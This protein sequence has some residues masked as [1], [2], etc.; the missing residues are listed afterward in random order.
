MMQKR[1]LYSLLLISFI[2][3]LAF[4]TSFAQTVTFESKNSLRCDNGVANINLS[5]ADSTGA[6]EIVFVIASGSGGAA[7]DNWSVA[8]DASFTKL[9]LRVVDTTSMAD[10]VLPDT[11]RISAIKTGPS[12]VLLAGNYLIAKVNFHTNDVCSGTVTMTGSTFAYAGGAC[13]FGCGMAVPVIQTQFANASGTAVSPAVVTTG[14]ITIVNTLPTIASIPNATLHWGQTFVDTAVGSD[15]DLAKGCEVLSYSKVS[16]PSALNVNSSTGAISWTTTGADVCTHTVTVK[17]TDKC[18]ASAQTSFDICVQNTPP[19]ITCPAT[20]IKIVLGDTAF[21]TI[22]GTDADF[23]PKPLIYKIVSFSGPG[24]PVINPATGAFSWPTVYDDIDFLGTFTACVEVTDS[25]NVCSPCS[26]SNADTCCFTITVDWGKVVIEKVHNQIQGQYTTVDITL[27]TNYPVGGF[28][29]LIQYD[30]SALTFTQAL[31][32]GFLTDCGWEYFTYRT[33]PFG[34]CGTGCPTGLIK[35]VAIAETNNGANHPGCFTNYPPPP[36]VDSVIAQLEFLVSNDFTLECQFVPI[37]FY[38]L[39]CTDNAFSNLKGD[40]LLI[41]RKVFDYVGGGGSDSYYEITDPTFG[42]PTW[43]GAQAECDIVNPDKPEV[44]RIIDFFD[45]GIDIVCADSIDARGDINLNGLAY[46]IADVVNFTNYFIVGLGAFTVNVNG[47]IAATDVNA[48]G[49]TLSVADLV[50]L[51]RVVVG[52]ALP[53][54]KISP[55]AVNYTVENGVVSVEGNMGAAFIVAEGN[56]TPTLLANN[57]LM[58]AQFDGQNTRILVYPPFDG[59]NHTESF[60]GEFVTVPSSIVSIEMATAEGAPAALRSVPK[61]YSLSQNYPNPFNPT[62]TI[63]FALPVAG[64]YDLAIYNVNGQLVQTFTGTAEAG[65][66]KVEWN[67]S[68]VASGMYIYK[69]TSGSFSAS[70]KML[71]VK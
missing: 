71:L 65:Y 52:D 28:D 42:F 61:T 66:Q 56:V 2:A 8:F 34:N 41:S 22:T 5:V 21:A 43:Y 20:P 44:W 40:S 37:K 67:A 7:F 13:G 16:G 64:S 32:G 18:G 1:N 58:E 33:G 60:T 15:G 46:E 39:D 62:T 53:Y 19:V 14:T 26:P 50:Y 35:L 59:V 51:I 48:D 69:L 47:Q 30:Q 23:G 45:G 55:E 38:W 31:V 4:S 11:I 36:G 29:L 54:P 49:L 68:N 9:N 70:R 3:V 10:H 27:G 6:V 24:T 57:M 17:V 12:D 63:E 25:A